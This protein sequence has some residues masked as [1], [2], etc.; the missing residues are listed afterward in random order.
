M[1]IFICTGGRLDILSLS[2]FEGTHEVMLSAY[3]LYPGRVGPAATSWCMILMNF[4]RYPHV[5]QVDT[6][7]RADSRVGV[8][9][10][11]FPGMLET[12]TR[13]IRKP[14]YYHVMNR[15]HQL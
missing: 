5:Q 15:S 1:N 2:Y 10:Q 4:S 9:C 13:I 3:I 12:N 8:A 11:M 7:R 6:G 14:I